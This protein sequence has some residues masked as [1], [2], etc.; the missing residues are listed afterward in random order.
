LKG[1]VHY[2]LGVDR[3]TAF[4]VIELVNPF[5]IVIDMKA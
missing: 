2:G 5:R 3:V 1:Q 4:R